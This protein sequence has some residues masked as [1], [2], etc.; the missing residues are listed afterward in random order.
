MCLGKRVRSEALVVHSIRAAP[1]GAGI[2]HVVSARLRK[3]LRA[4]PLVLVLGA[5]SRAQAQAV[6][7]SEASD[8]RSLGDHLFPTT[9]LVPS[10]FVS[11][12]L[13]FRQGILHVDVNDYP[14]TR[15]RARDITALGLSET[16][17]IGDASTAWRYAASAARKSL[18]ARSFGRSSRSGATSPMNWVEERRYRS[19]ERRVGKG[20]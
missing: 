20:G 2:D 5:G 8:E 18:P 10:P 11:T 12:H 14:F 3:V 19:E 4:I 7:S 13:S 17:E 1:R 6:T 15:E 16:I 9:M